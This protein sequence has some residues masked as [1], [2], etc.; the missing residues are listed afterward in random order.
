[1]LFALILTITE[2]MILIAATRWFPDQIYLVSVASAI[3]AIVMVRWGW[4]ASIHAVLSGVIMCLIMGGSLQQYAIYCIGNLMG[5]MALPL[6]KKIGVNKIC[7]N[8][9]LRILYGA[10]VLVLMQT[11]RAL[12][13]LAFGNGIGDVLSFYLTDALSLVFTAVILWVAGN[14]DGIL[15]DQREYVVRIQQAEG[16]V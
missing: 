11:G 14:Q 16:T 15:E 2:S 13:S 9:I 7:D 4:Y 10:L 3:T 12:I 8:A 6:I 1:M 5:L